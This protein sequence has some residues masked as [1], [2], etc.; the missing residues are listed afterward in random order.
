MDRAYKSGASTTAPTAP[1]SP[2]IGYP[3]SGDPVAGV[4][5]TVPG[6]Y[7]YHML[8][9]ELR[10]IVVAGGLTP[11]HLVLNQ[12]LTAILA[13][14]D[15]YSLGRSQTWHSVI[16]SRALGVTYYNTTDRPISLAVFCSAVTTGAIGLRIN[17]VG[18]NTMA[19][20]Q[21]GGAALSFQAIIP[22]GASYM[23]YVSAGSIDLNTWFEL[24]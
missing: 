19:Y 20:G 8:V 1:A 10:A 24:R 4:P 11:N 9:E 2:S 13:L 15:K 22:P 7:L 6:P 18:N 14:I 3:T 23:I 5:K 17:G 12:V 16:A 21:P